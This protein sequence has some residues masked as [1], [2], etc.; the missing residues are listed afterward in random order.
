[1]CGVCMNNI[2]QALSRAVA[3]KAEM[4]GFPLII[5]SSGALQVHRFG[6]P[7]IGGVLAFCGGALAAMILVIAVTC[8]GFLNVLPKRNSSLRAFGGIHVV[9]VMGSAVAG[10]AVTLPLNQSAAF[11]VASFATVVTFEVLLSIELHVAA[12]GTRAISPELCSL[13]GDEISS[14]APPD[15]VSVHVALPQARQAGATAIE[16]GIRTVAVEQSL[17][18]EARL[19]VD[20][21]LWPSEIIG[22]APSGARHL[23]DVPHSLC[24]QI[25]IRPQER[26]SATVEWVDVFGQG[27]V[28][29]PE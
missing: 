14:T 10:W 4:Y 3:S 28:R 15:S 6:M 24:E 21:A 26:T 11:F 16:V 13:D 5:W 8:R 1:L 29:P 18:S 27:V 19:P 12:M 23:S 7:G 25:D 20:G 17:D 9:S 22:Q 2:R